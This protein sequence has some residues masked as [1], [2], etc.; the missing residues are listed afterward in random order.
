MQKTW[1][2]PL[3]DARTGISPSTLLDIH[4]HETQNLS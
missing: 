3:G 1:E 2:K 4:A